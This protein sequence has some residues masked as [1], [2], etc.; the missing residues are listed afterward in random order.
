MPQLIVTETHYIYIKPIH[1][2]L[3]TANKALVF[4]YIVL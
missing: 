1:V 2:S 3:T 4:M